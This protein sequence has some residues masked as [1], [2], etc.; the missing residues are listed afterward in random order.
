MPCSIASISY[1]SSNQKELAPRGVILLTGCVVR[2]VPDAQNYDHNGYHGFEIYLGSEGGKRD[3]RILYARTDLERKKWMAALQ[4][5]SCKPPIEDVY[6]IGEELGSGRFS[7]VVQA[8]HRVSGETVAV[9]IINKNK[10]GLMEKE[11]L[12]T[13]IAILKLVEHPN[14]IRLKV[15]QFG[16]Y[17]Y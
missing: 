4:H 11:L 7:Q 13:E 12:R 2:I 17:T 10:V 16:S 8:T 9:K 5:A 15:Q 3:Q 1:W 6:T 14:I